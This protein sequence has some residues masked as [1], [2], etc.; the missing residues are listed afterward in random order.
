MRYKLLASVEGDLI[1]NGNTSVEC[2][3]LLIE[4][5]VDASNRLS[6]VAISLKATSG[7]NNQ[8][9]R[10]CRNRKRERRFN[11]QNRRR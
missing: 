2:D 5:S 4:L 9:C 7:K 1:T 11:I 10:F 3:D 6:T 8:F